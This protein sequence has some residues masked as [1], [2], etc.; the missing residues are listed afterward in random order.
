MTNQPKTLFEKIWH[1]HTVRPETA[2]TPA[3]TN[4]STRRGYA[5]RAASAA[6]TAAPAA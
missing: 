5:D 2:E 3:V 6:S 1:T 4:A